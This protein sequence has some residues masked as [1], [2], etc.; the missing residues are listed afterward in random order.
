MSLTSFLKD[1]Q[2]V[3]AKFNEQFSKPKFGIKRELLAPPLTTNYQLIGTAFDYLLRFYIQ[4]LNPQAITKEWIAVNGFS[5][6]DGRAMSGKATD[7]GLG[8]KAAELM[9][10]AKENY[11]LFLAT[12]QINDDLLRST[13]ALAHYENVYRAWDRVLDIEVDWIQSGS[14]VD[15]QDIEDLR[16]LIS[17]VDP[18]MFK[19]KS[20]CLLNP[21]F[22]E[23]TRLV[24][25]AD[26]DVV[27]DDAMIELKTTKDFSFKMPWFQQLMGY[28]CLYKIGTIDGMPPGHTI[29]R[30]GVYFSRHGYLHT[31][32][33]ADVIDESKFPAFLDWF[34]ERA[35]QA[36]PTLQRPVTPPS[37]QNFRGG[38]H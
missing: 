18:P 30:L 3:R 29:N 1:N 15:T 28:Y 35:K 9:L 2:D 26:M 34:V 6:V 14:I 16:K 12:G 21:T 7:R 10:K 8:E 24:R 37:D 5:L 38:K 22:G 4:R 13:I 23:A 27:I 33:V 19:A 20:I 25:G 11:A 36:F 32:N 31:I 17:I